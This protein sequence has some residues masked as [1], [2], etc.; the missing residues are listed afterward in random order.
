MLSG[1]M[2]GMW[3]RWCRVRQFV[4]LF[5]NSFGQKTVFDRLASLFEEQLK[6]FPQEKIYV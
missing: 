2:N 3:W 4:F 5:V 1:V 6:I